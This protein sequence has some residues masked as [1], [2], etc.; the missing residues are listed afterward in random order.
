MPATVKRAP[1]QSPRTVYRGKPLHRE[2]PNIVERA[3]EM[4]PAE[5]AQLKTDFIAS[6]N[7]WA[8]R[9]PT[10]TFRAKSSA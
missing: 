10:G 7:A 2:A 4:T 8:D 9:H 1:K 5:I 6:L 3:A